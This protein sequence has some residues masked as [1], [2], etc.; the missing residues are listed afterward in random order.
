MYLFYGFVFL[1]K[2]PVIIMYIAE[3]KSILFLNLLFIPLLPSMDRHKRQHI[4]CCR[5]LFF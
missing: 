5:E 2:Y 4:F 3:S 1:L